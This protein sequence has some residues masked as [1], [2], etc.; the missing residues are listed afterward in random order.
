WWNERESIA[1]F[2]FQKLPIHSFDGRVRILCL[3]MQMFSRSEAAFCGF[4][5]LRHIFRKRTYKSVECA[6]HVLLNTCRS[7]T[8]QYIGYYGLWELRQ[9]KNTRQYA[10]IALKST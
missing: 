8:S 3:E 4:C 7:K 9:P 6:F 2:G 1:P 10:R 5:G